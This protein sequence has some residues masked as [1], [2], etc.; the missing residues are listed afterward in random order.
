M[1]VRSIFIILLRHSALNVD[2]DGENV[3]KLD[4]GLLTQYSPHPRISLRKISVTTMTSTTM[5]MLSVMMIAAKMIAAATAKIMM[6]AAHFAANLSPRT[7]SGPTEMVMRM[8]AVVAITMRILSLMIL[9]TIATAMA[10]TPPSATM[11]KRATKP[12]MMRRA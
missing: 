2:C 3:E 6:N 10:V 4:V 7:N 12:P 9:K 1:N 8:I 11:T 5:K